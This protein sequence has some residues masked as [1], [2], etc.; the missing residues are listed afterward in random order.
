M[1]CKKCG[2]EIPE[3]KNHC[4]KCGVERFSPSQTLLRKE[5]RKIPLWFIIAVIIVVISIIQTKQVGT[6]ILK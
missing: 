4:R 2:T 1:F 5:R 3:T 6:S